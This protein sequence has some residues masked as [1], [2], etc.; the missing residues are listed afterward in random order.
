M[1]GRPPAAR[2]ERATTE[3][4][5][6]ATF[7]APPASACTLA[8]AGSFGPD[9]ISKST[10]DDASRLLKSTSAFG[11]AL[12]QDTAETTAFTNNGLP[13]NIQD[14][15]DNTTAYL[16]DG[17]DR[18]SRITYP[19][20]SYEEFTYDAGG[21]VTQHRLRDGTSFVMT[22]D[23]L[24][25]LTFRNAPGAQPDVT[26]AYDNFGRPT[27][28]SQSGHSLGY[29]YD[30][31]S[32]VVSAVQPNGTVSYQY[33]AAGRRTRL[34]W[35][36]TFYVQY[37]Y[38][39]AGAM[40]A[41]RQNGATS[42]AGV[43]ARFVYDDLGRRVLLSRANGAGAGT[44]YSYDGA[45][46]L[47]SLAHDA[48]GTANDVTFGYTY[49]PASQIVGRTVSNPAYRWGVAADFTDAY[50]DN[51]LNQ[52]ASVDG[53]ALTHDA[54]GNTTNDTVKA[55][56]YDADNRLVTAGTATQGFDPEG[57]LYQTSNAS[58]TFRLLY[59]GPDVIAEF[60][61][62]G[63][64]LRRHA[65]GPGLD[66]PIV[67]FEGT[68]TTTRAAASSRMPTA[69]RRS[70]RRTSM[71][72]SA[73]PPPATPGA[74]ATPARCGSATPASITTRREATPRPRPLPPARPHRLRRRHEPLR[75]CRQ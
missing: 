18:L 29:V 42:G 21:N 45:S 38:D 14:A 67:W 69:P 68:G 33:D 57:R 25:R 61:A 32:R 60:N 6:S 2:I 70:R 9:R 41:M 23:D 8:T 7:A 56:A 63:T 15:G 64:L 26:F 27:T 72:R 28:V 50:S 40:T 74:F 51:A 75:L 12:A 34:S 36:G 46:R 20:G 73:S 62:S 54:R 47:L 31:L 5:V 35:P 44:S 11:T 10:Y 16:Y 49:N 53:A 13:S 17:H 30:Q 48:S 43:L 59:D 52:I 37:D 39:V 22:Y 71:I 1:P 66:E 24:S 65:H 3:A 55:Y 4:H 19:G 58:S